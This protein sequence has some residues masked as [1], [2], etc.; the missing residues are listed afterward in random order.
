METQPQTLEP[1]TAERVIDVIRL[2]GCD[3]KLILPVHELDADLG[4]DS[5]EIVEFGMLIRKE[6][7]VEEKA[8]SLM[9]ARTVADVIARIDQ[10]F[11][12]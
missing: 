8:I 4:I 5:T 7:A 11:G 6:F 9:G 1:Q 2:L 3:A 10:Y 12:K